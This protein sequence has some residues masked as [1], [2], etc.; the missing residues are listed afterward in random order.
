MSIEK[1]VIVNRWLHQVPEINHVVIQM[2]SGTNLGYD[3]PFQTKEFVLDKLVPSSIKGIK[4]LFDTVPV[5]AGRFIGNEIIN[6]DL[7]SHKLSS[8]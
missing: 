5:I 4:N 2:V 3:C 6:T 8:G 1:E 7:K